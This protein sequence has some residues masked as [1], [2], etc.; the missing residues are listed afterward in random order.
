MTQKNWSLEAQKRIEKLENSV[1]QVA[2]EPVNREKPADTVRRMKL[3][4]YRILEGHFGNHE[5]KRGDFGIDLNIYPFMWCR[6]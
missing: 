2:K 1:V 3:P 4:L 6:F 5:F